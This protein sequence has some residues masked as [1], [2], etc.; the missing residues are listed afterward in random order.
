MLE[1][2]E[3][4]WQNRSHIK[5][6]QDSADILFLDEETSLVKKGFLFEDVEDETFLGRVVGEKITYK[7]KYKEVYNSELSEVDASGVHFTPIKL[8]DKYHEI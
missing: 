4:D 5:L 6:A 2:Y 7:I 3:F 8:R 1:F